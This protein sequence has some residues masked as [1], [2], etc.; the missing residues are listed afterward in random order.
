MSVGNISQ[1]WSSEILT[2]Q[3][4]HGVQRVS[5]VAGRN[6]AGSNPVVTPIS[7]SCGR[8]A[9]QIDLVT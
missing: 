5:T 4:K 6:D 2:R 3:E 9:S 8:V 7:E 1:N